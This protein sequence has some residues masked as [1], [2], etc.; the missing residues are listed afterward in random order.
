MQTTDPVAIMDNG[1]DRLLDSLPALFRAADTSGD[2]HRLLNAFGAI[3]FGG[4][5]PARP[6]IERAIDAI[7][8][9]CTPL[10]PDPADS[11]LQCGDPFLPWLAGWVAFSPHAMF[12]PAPLRRIVAGIVPL[13]SRRGTR[14][15]LERLLTLGFDEIAGVAID[16]APAAGLRVGHARIGEDSRL[17]TDSPFTFHVDVTLVAGQPL[18]R[19]GT[20]L[21]RRIRAMIDFARPAHTVYRLRFSS[22][23]AFTEDSQAW[24]RNT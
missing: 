15:Y 5:D 10:S 7:P 23:T 8:H 16:E 9:L 18:P 11:D 21:E 4:D 22:P 13:Y 14:A 17:G 3:L 6:G 1:A 2:L 24:K 20:P 12:A 19:T